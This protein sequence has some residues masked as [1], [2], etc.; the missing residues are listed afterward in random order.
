M[1][2]MNNDNIVSDFFEPVDEFEK[3]A[4]TSKTGEAE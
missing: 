2:M 4:K 1:E 3:K